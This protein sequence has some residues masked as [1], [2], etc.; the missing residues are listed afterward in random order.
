MP[1]H[2][3]GLLTVVGAVA[4]SIG[5]STQQTPAT[6]PDTRA[7]DEHA[8]RALDSAWVR[9]LAARN[10]DA[11]TAVY[12]DSAMVLA[13]AEPIAR[14]KEAIRKVFQGIMSSPGYALTFSPD[15]V[16]V[17]G[18][19]AYEVGSYALTTRNKSGKLQTQK[20]KYFDVWARQA[21]GMWRVTADVITTT[22]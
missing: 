8:I 13:P 11:G 7:A 17:S 10:V 16:T 14:G 1:T 20:A 4:A 6:P 12:T 2:R 3:V 21:D 15:R 19:M 5:C 9:G 22:Q 18:D